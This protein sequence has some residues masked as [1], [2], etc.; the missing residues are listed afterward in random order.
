[1]TPATG[2]LYDGTLLP[3]AGVMLGA[4]A[5]ASAIGLTLPAAAAKA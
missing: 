3:V 4:S 1:M 2:V 5:T